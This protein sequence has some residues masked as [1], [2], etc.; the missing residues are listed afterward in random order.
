[1]TTP[2]YWRRRPVRP[3]SSPF[4][5]LWDRFERRLVLPFVALATLAFLFQLTRALWSA[6]FGG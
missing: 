4:G 1:M 3:Q 6:Y 5:E 2:D